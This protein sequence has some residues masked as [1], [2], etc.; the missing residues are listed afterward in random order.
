MAFTEQDVTNLQADNE[1]LH[2]VLL[3]IRKI[4][5]G[6][7]HTET[8]ILE[9]VSK[10]KAQAP[11]TVVHTDVVNSNPIM[12]YFSYSHLNPELQTI[13]K[14]VGEL[15]EVMNQLLPNSAEK[16][17]GLRKLLEAKDCFVRANLPPVLESSST[18]AEG[19][20]SDQP[21]IFKTD[22]EERCRSSNK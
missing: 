7:I 3:K 19:F 6:S 12:R 10:L 1:H 20:K 18:F 17:A 4:V 5:T 13:S 11:T 9:E 22:G 2:A 16:T 8:D 21:I 14:P 15:A